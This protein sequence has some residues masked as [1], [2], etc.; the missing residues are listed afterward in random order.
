LGGA[1]A[2]GNTRAAAAF[3]GQRTIHHATHGAKVLLVV[4]EQCIQPGMTM[5]LAV[6][7]DMPSG[8]VV[9]G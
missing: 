9:T 3:T 4:R 7:S 6:Q 2:P 8:A 1:G 5:A